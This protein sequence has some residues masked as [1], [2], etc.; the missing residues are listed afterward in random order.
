MYWLADN[1]RHGETVLTAMAFA[2]TAAIL[3]LGRKRLILAIPIALVFL[4]LAAIAIP[5]A[6]PARPA[7]QRNACIF[8]LA[9]IRDAKIQWAGAN[10]KPSGAIPTEDDLWGTNGNTGI[11]RLPLICPRGGTYTIGAMGQNPS[12][13]FSNKGHR[14]ELQPK[15][16]RL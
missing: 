13:S 10:N 15:P 12:C 2:F 8:N 11:L 6:I 7:A 5:S 14:L 16:G 1:T 9:M 4:L 3:W